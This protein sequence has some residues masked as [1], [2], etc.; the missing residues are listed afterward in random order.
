MLETRAAIR[1]N[2]DKI[3]LFFVPFRN[4]FLLLRERTRPI[5]SAIRLR[6][7]CIVEYESRIRDRPGRLVR[8][9]RQNNPFRSNE[10]ISQDFLSKRS[11]Q[12]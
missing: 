12:K 3:R 1:W 10:R 8:N 6:R 11:Y 5:A 2:N 7:V 4:N 9:F